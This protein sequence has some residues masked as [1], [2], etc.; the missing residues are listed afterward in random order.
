M[1][2]KQEKLVGPKGCDQ[3]YNILLAIKY[4]Q[5]PSSIPGPKLF[6]SFINNLDNST[7]YTHSTVPLM[8]TTATLEGRTVIQRKVGRLQKQSKNLIRFIKGKCG[9]L[10]L[11]GC[12]STQQYTL[13]NSWLKKDFKET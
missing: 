5:N 3:Q 13:G 1:G 7:E 8:A 11:S 9:V 10:Y 2:E 12:T 6:N 4:W